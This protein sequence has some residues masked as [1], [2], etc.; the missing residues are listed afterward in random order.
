ME[1]V[2]ADYMARFGISEKARRLLL[3]PKCQEQS[4]DKARPHDPDN[5]R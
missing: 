4:Y 1:E 5:N 2:L 3:Y